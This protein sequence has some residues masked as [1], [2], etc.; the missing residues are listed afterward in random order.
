MASATNTA[1]GF[2]KK[3]DKGTTDRPLTDG[4]V[5]LRWLELGLSVAD[6]DELDMGLIMDMI[7]EKAN[8]SYEYPY[9]ATQKDFDNF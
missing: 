7:I 2:K 6:I 1:R 4:L 5:M 9:I 8:D 3:V